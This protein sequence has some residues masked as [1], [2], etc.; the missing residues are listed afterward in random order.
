MC[1]GKK[2][3]CIMNLKDF[4]DTA[5]KALDIANELKQERK[6]CFKRT[7]KRKTRTQYGL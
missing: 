7:I 3:G 5:K 6:S 2:E 4:A 1:N